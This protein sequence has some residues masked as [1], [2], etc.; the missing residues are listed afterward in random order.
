MTTLHA[1]SQFKPPYRNPAV[2]VVTNLPSARA[3][4]SSNSH[5]PDRAQFLS[6][7]SKMSQ[8]TNMALT[9]PRAIAS[10]MSPVI[11]M[12]LDPVRPS[13]RF[14]N[15]D[16]LRE[17]LEA[18]RQEAEAQANR[19]VTQKQATVAKGMMGL[20]DKLR[21][22]WIELHKALEKNWLPS[23]RECATLTVS[24]NGKMYLIGGLN[25]DACKEMIEGTV[26]GDN[27]NWE[28]IPYKSTEVIQGRQCHTSVSFQNKIYTF[29]GC[30]NFNRKRQIRECTNQLMEYEIHDR[31]IEVIKT[32]GVPVS[33]RKNHCAAVYKRSMLVYGG[34]LENGTFDQDM[35]SLNFDNFEWLKITPKQPITPFTQGA[36]CSVILSANKRAQLNGEGSKKVSF[37]PTEPPIEGIFYFG[38]KS[39]KGE[40]LNK[41]RYF[42]PVMID[43]R[44]VHG[45]F[46]PIKILGQ[47]P[48]GRFG[49]TMNYLPV[50]NAL[51]VAGGKNFYFADMSV[52]P[53]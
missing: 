34:V 40:C 6:C 11:S 38:G 14:V 4:S 12:Q 1:V 30:F 13:P 46:Q 45:D 28:R 2:S 44:I 42:K 27:V 51:V 26:R 22:P 41:L 52:R 17:K 36:C 8:T 31:R 37:H 50:A 49:H 19:E 33:A 5:S 7:M 3:G 35:I 10:T 20:L 48:C 15:L 47:P 29:G 25:Y 32:V 21:Q 53:Q 18:A 43:N 23:P 24:D 16:K 39:Q 9:S